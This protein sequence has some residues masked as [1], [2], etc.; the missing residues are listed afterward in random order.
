M[1][2]ALRRRPGSADTLCSSLGCGKPLKKIPKVEEKAKFR[3]GAQLVHDQ[4]NRPEAGKSAV[5]AAV[6]I[7][8]LGTIKRNGNPAAAGAAARNPLMDVSNVLGGRGHSGGDCVQG[9]HL[10]VE[11]MAP[12]TKGK[13]KSQKKE[14]KGKKGGSKKEINTSSLIE[15][16][17]AQGA[18]M[19]KVDLKLVPSCRFAFFSL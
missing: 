16:S 7:P 5:T 15:A 6:R 8:I 14:G 9:S 3:G 10:Q 1:L 19:E 13:Q 2:N 12:S 4:G 11:N 17:L 18:S